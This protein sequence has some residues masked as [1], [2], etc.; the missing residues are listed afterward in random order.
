MRLCRMCTEREGAR[1]QTYDRLGVKATVRT[2]VTLMGSSHH[3]QKSQQFF[4]A[5][6]LMKL[7]APSDSL[8]WTIVK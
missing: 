5:L 4:K 6:C 2:A 8:S 1:N 3:Q 7:S